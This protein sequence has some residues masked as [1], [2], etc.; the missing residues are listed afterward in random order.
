[1]GAG[2]NPLIRILLVDDDP[3]IRESL[4]MILGLQPDF[5][6]VGTCHNGAEAAD[7][8]E[9]NANVTVVLMDI[10]MPTCDGVEGTRRI[11]AVAPDVRVIILTTFDDDDYVVQAI[12]CGAEGF[13]L[14]NN[15]PATIMEAIRTV[16]SGHLL[17]QA[18]VARKLTRHLEPSSKGSQERNPRDTL[19][20]W[21]LT[22]TQCDITEAIAEGLSN[23]E[24]AQR[25]FWSEGTVRNQ[26]TEILSK[27]E[28]RDRTQLAIFYL[29]HCV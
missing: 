16:A 10:R 6:V 28:L 27:L 4:M 20:T 5:E 7:F 19:Q 12:R 3:Y 8:I 22:P 29:K 1:M 17:L 24:I 18:D 26:V 13:L 15:A 9:R 14:K 21:G 23:K 11:K 25:Y 2:G